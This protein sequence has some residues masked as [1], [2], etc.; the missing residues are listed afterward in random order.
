MPNLQPSSNHLE[1]IRSAVG[2]RF[3]QICMTPKNRMVDMFH[4]GTPSK[5]KEHILKELSLREGRIRVLI[6]T[7]AFGMGVNCKGVNRVIH[8]GPSKSLESYIQECGRAGRDGS[9]SLCFLLHNG[10]LQSHCAHNMRDYVNLSSC[11]RELISSVFSERTD[12]KRVHD[13][14]CCDICSRNCENGFKEDPCTASYF[15]FIQ[16]DPEGCEE[17]IKTRHVTKDQIKSTSKN[18]HEYKDRSNAS[19]VSRVNVTFGDFQINQVLKHVD[20]ILNYETL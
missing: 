1:N 10:F 13:C 19:F 20:K 4:A 17:I 7:V 15:P 8:F 3:L 11:R 18:L 2:E 6:C 16:E 5:A 14:K 9:E 12:P